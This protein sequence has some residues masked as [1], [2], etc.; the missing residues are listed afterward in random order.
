MTTAL[1]AAR[2]AVGW[3]KPELIARLRET[4]TTAGVWVAAPQSLRVMIAG[5]ENGYRHPTEL[6]QGLLGR[7]YGRDAAELGFTT[8]P[9]SAGTG[10]GAVDPDATAALLYVA[11]LGTPALPRVGG[12]QA[13]FYTDCVLTDPHC[14][15]AD[16][17]AAGLRRVRAQDP[18]WL[19]RTRLR[20]CTDLAQAARAAP[21]LG[22]GPVPDWVKATRLH[23]CGI[24][25][26]VF[27]NRAG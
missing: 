8:A 25:A 27:T 5:W 9:G 2:H 6:Y 17:L 7:V 19:N 13:R 11:P 26:Q 4:A 12:S 22:T 20:I 10:G 24:A 16:E 14:P 3:T 15:P 21:E 23:G 1:K 18:P